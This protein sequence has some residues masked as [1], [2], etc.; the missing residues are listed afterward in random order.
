M[1]PFFRHAADIAVSSVAAMPYATMPPAPLM[2]H[3][4]ATLRQYAAADA[5][6]LPMMPLTLSIFAA[7]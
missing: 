1:S 4:F 3:Y 2:P 7:G 5:T 6:L